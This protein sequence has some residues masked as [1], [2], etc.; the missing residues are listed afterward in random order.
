MQEIYNQKINQKIYEETLDNGLKITVFPMKTK[1]K[2]IIWGANVGSIDNKFY[3]PGDK[4]ITILPDGIAHY[5]EHKLF[6]Q[7]S[8]KN[9]L[10]TLTALGVDANAYTSNDHTA[11]LYVCTENYEVALNEFMDYVQNPHFTKENVDKERGIIEQE[12][13]MYEDYPEWA[14]YLNA[15]KIMYH[16]NEIRLD[17]AGTIESIQEID[18][19]KLYK[20]YN[21]FYR[22]DN[23]YMV[24]VGDFEPEEAV[25]QIK[26]RMTMPKAEGEIKRVY[27]DEPEDIVQKYIEEEM[28]ISMPML[29]VGYKDNNKDIPKMYKSLAVDMIESIL[30]GTGS[31]FYKEMYETERILTAPGATY[32]YSKTYGHIMIQ[33]TTQYPEEV[34]EAISKTVE[35]AVNEGLKDEDFERCRRKIYGEFIRAF[36]DPEEV[37]PG[38]ISGYFKGV[39]T[40][41]Y[42]DV[43]EKITKKDVEKVLKEVFNEKYKVVSVIKTKE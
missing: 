33:T 11:Y 32:E 9:S 31:D 29:L 26:D 13:M 7:E 18:E 17:E 8:G 40:I 37:A 12:I 3:C 4:D 27:N 2:F 14:V 19:E 42:L 20:L 10:D 36:D 23:M 21:T 30:F 16:A 22:P 25:Q 39:N 28:D 15:M 34:A 35:K 38:L 6:E 1:I 5:L 24:L 43:F 41:D